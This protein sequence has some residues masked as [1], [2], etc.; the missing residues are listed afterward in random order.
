MPIK[1][2][3]KGQKKINPKEVAKRKTLAEKLT[4]DLEDKG[5]VFF[6][7]TEH[8]GTLNIDTEYLSLPSD[9]TEVHSK[10]LGQYLNTL[11]QQ[12]AYMRTLYS[13]NEANYEEAKRLYYD[14]Y[15]VVYERLTEENPKMSE[16]AK[17]LYCNNDPTVHEPFMTHKDFGVKL[18]MVDS[19]IETLTEFIFLVSREISRRSGDW[20]EQ[21]RV[22]NLK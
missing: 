15:Y 13:I 14:K 11:T 5:V 6:T 4:E 20:K 2:I 22:N 1:K 3:N 10:E 16:K 18:S 7:P 12:K 17:E 8:G 19:T 9:L 21:E